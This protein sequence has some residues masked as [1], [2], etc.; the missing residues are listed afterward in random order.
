MFWKNH[1]RALGGI[2]VDN[3]LLSTL[4]NLDL[5]T[6]TKAFSELYIARTLLQ[7]CY[8]CFFSPYRLSGGKVSS[9]LK[10]ITAAEI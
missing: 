3:C 7:S 6:F 4:N 5:L 9:R 8:G 2:G 10:N 1:A